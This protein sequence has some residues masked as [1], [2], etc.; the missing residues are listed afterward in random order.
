MKLQMRAAGAWL[1]AGSTAGAALAPGTGNNLLPE[2]GKG[3]SPA[4]DRAPPA[5]RAPTTSRLPPGTSTGHSEGRAGW[6]RCQRL[7]HAG[8]DPADSCFLWTL[9][10]PRIPMEKDASRS[11]LLH[12][13]WTK[14]ISDLS[15]PVKIKVV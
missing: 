9:L 4:G 5:Q 13:P 3:N 11:Q 15:E 14:A 12:M 2:Q 7:L 1:G 6:A 10:N 8:T